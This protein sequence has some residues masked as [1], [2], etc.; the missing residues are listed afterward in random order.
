[1]DLVDAV[2]GVAPDPEVLAVVRHTAG[3]VAGHG[4]RSYHGTVCIVPVDYVR[5]GAFPNEFVAV[6]PR[7]IEV[8]RDRH[9]DGA[10]RPTVRSRR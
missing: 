8:A 6:V 4:E 5:E 3:G 7:D 2:V 10:N 1:M 9:P